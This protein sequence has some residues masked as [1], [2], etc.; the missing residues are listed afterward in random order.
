MVDGARFP[1]DKTAQPVFQSDGV[2]QGMQLVRAQGE[3]IQVDESV[4][5]R[6]GEEQRVELPMADG[7]G[8]IV[9]VAPNARTRDSY[10]VIDDVQVVAECDTEQVE[11]VAAETCDHILVNGRIHTI[12]CPDCGREITPSDRLDFDDQVIGAACPDC[13]TWVDLETK[14]PVAD[15]WLT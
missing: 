1:S 8:T 14:H 15:R 7:T 11:M 12:F 10:V 3:I 9:L 13:R 5:R 4:R 6:L 2:Q